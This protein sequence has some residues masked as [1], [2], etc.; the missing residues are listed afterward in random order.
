MWKMMPRAPVAFD[1]I[2]KHLNSPFNY[3]F[4]IQTDGSIWFDTM[5]TVARVA[6]DLSARFMAHWWQPIAEAIV[7]EKIFHWRRNAIRSSIQIDRIAVQLTLH[8]ILIPL[9]FIWTCMRL[10]LGSSWGRLLHHIRMVAYA[11]VRIGIKI[12]HNSLFVS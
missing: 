7:S 2:D 11:A 8:F 3:K 10:K 4:S 12:G 6:F 1:L 5:D 9:Y